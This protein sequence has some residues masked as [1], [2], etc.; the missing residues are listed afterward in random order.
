MLPTL[1]DGDLL[2]VDRT[3]PVRPQDLVVLRLPERPLAIKRAVRREPGGWWVERDNPRAGTDSWTV[4]PVDEAGVVGVA[5]VRLWPRPRRLGA[6]AGF[7][8]C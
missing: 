7:V 5:V 3:L 8:S 6:R 4:G 2:L 1:A